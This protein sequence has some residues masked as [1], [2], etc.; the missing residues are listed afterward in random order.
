MRFR[1]LGVNGP[2][3]AEVGF[4]AMNLSISGRPNEADAIR[5]LNRAIDA[6]VTLIDTADVYCLDDDDIGH[7]ERLIA[8]A[9]KGRRNGVLIA[10][11][12]GV[13]RPRGAWTN[14]ARPDRLVQACDSSLRALGVSR[15]DL[16]QLHAPDPR[17]PFAE[18]VGALARLREK[19]K[20]WLVGL[21]NVNAEQIDEAS[22]IV[23]IASVQNRYNLLDRRAEWDGVLAACE[24]L[25]IAFLPYAPLG[26]ALQVAKLVSFGS[27]G[28]AAARLGVSPHRLAIAWILARSP[29]AIPIPGARRPEHIEDCTKAADL[30][31]CD[32][33]ESFLSPKRRWPSTG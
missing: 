4:G 24:R 3:V 9:L 31:M 1:K 25:D 17:V 11:K 16:Y 6:G 18:S 8:K 27:L 22:Q 29:V 21:S 15:I 10:T 19:G 14:D 12:G 23:P 20:V 26:G 32:V 13:R 2:M 30:R 33:E 28:E 5:A 7:N